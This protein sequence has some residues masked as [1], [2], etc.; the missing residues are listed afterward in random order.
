MDVFFENLQEIDILHKSLEKH[1][2]QGNY[3]TSAYIDK[4][5]E[6]Y[7]HKRDPDEVFSIEVHKSDYNFH[8]ISRENLLH[9]SETIDYISY[10]QV[11]QSLSVLLQPSYLLRRNKN[12]TYLD[13]FLQ[14]NPNQFANN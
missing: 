14:K 13:L 6:F 5:E 1:E 8:K 9:M 4:I 7:I 11:L 10:L 3:R 12:N 2:I